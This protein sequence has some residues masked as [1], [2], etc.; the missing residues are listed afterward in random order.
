MLC[1]K[2]VRGEVGGRT[3]HSPPDGG[4]EQSAPPTWDY[5]RFIQRQKKTATCFLSN[6]HTLMHTHTHT[7]AF[8]P[9]GP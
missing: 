6:T 9:A 5:L 7:L 1:Q 3:L 4:G 2:E 8:S